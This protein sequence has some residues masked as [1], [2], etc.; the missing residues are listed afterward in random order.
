MKDATPNRLRLLAIAPAALVGLLLAL[1][2]VHSPRA[3]EPKR[4]DKTYPKQVLLIRHAEKPPDE[5]KSVHLSK[6]GEERAKALPQLFVKSPTRPIPFPRPDF[7]FATHNS[8]SSHRPVETVTPL[9]RK[10]GLPINDAFK[11]DVP[12]MRGLSNEVFGKKK[13]QGKTVLVCWHHGTMPEMAGLLRATGYPAKVGSKV[14]DR[15]WQI[16]YDKEGKTTFANLPQRLL[17]GDS[18]K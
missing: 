9:S 14:F 1:A 7:L 4:A 15:V 2:I 16:T 10:L 3:D 13:Y 17:P 6:Q 8:K 12:G 5:D 18:K 11:N